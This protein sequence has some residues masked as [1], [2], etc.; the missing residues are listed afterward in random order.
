MTNNKYAPDEAPR[1]KSKEELLEATNDTAAEKKAEQTELLAAVAEGE[2]GISV[3]D[4]EWVQIG[5]VDVKVK[6][7]MPGESL[8]AIE[9]AKRLAERENTS[10]TLE[11]IATMKDGMTAV[12]E[13]IKL[14]SRDIEVAD[15]E[16]IRDFWGGMVNTWGIEGFQEAADIVLEPAVT[17]LKSKGETANGFR[18]DA[19]RDSPRK[20]VR[21]DG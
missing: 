14:E 20:G 4:Y 10:D 18:K 9:R 17:D 16:D 7:W 12:T 1:G 15:E 19:G 11:G 21:D 6:A 5:Q 2:Q 8:N 13:T 3:E